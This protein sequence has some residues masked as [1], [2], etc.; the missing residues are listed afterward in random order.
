MLPLP[1]AV[2]PVTVPEVT[3]AVQSKSAPVTLLVGVKFSMSPSQIVSVSVLLETSATGETMTITGDKSLSQ[4]L[5]VAV[6]M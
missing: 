1:L 3:E 6:M 5:A 2:T 4:P